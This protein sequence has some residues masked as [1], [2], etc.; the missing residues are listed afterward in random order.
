MKRTEQRKLIKI[1]VDNKNTRLTL[2]PPKRKISP[3]W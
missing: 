3:V 2:L 1:R